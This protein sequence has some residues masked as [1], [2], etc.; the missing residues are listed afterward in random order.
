MTRFR[1]LLIFAL[2]IALA[3]APAVSGNSGPTYWEGTTASGM[4]VTG[5][6]CPIVVDHEELT[7]DIGEFPLEYYEDESAFTDYMPHVTAEYTFRNPSDADV[8]VQMLFPFGTTPQYAPAGRMLP[9]K[10]AVTAD[11]EPVETV[12]R[13]SLV[14]GDF[15]MAEDSS[16]LSNDYREH[17]F[18]SPEMP[19]TKYVFKPSGVDWTDRDYIRAK[20][21]LDSDPA[22]TK[23]ILNPVNSF[24]T[25]K[26]HALVG[27]SVREGE[28]VELY[29]IGA[30]PD[31]DFRWELFEGG[32]R[33]DG[34]MES[35]GTEGTTLR[36]FLL[37]ARPEGSDIS[38]ADWYNA[39]VQLLGRVECGHGYL[40]AGTGMELMG[41]YEYEL[42][43]P[44]GQTLV[45]TV[46]APLYPDIHAGWEPAIYTYEY[47]LSPAQGW[48]AFGSLNITVKTP[49]HMTQCNL[50]GFEKTPEGYR[51][52][53]DSLPN[54]DLI[55]VL[56]SVRNPA[57]P[58]SGPRITGWLLAGAGALIVLGLIRRK[59]R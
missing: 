6:N 28:T 41:W 45:N 11:G 36:E 57:R 58:G 2:C 46:T 54:K 59:R 8:T 40:D 49:Y 31:G 23:Y 38:E 34:T 33:I 47:L 50:E 15:D 9:W 55:F 53:L 1:D 44:A 19:V 27:S 51:L 25:E 10:Y 16:K 7:F 12:L 30:V 39:A 3:L 17:H 24:E 56:S 43:I 35:V 48:A 29:V 13:H 18:Y 37:S 22:D 32:E 14:W 4:T 20:V 21:R 42:T 26:D 5:D 52:E